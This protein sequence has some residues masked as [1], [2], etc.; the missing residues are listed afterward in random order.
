MIA[1]L[2]LSASQAICQV[3]SYS[4]LKDNCKLATDAP[5]IACVMDSSRIFP[6]NSDFVTAAG[7]HCFTFIEKGLKIMWFIQTI[8]SA[9][10]CQK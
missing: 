4:I 10:G 8:V 1:Y 5:F 9:L 7:C 3:I 6:C 2:V